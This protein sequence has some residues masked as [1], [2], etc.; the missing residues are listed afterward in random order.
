MGASDGVT[1]DRVWQGEPERPKGG[2]FGFVPAAV[3]VISDQGEAPTG[4]LN[5]N[6]VAPAGVKADVYQ[7]QSLPGFQ[8]PVGETG[9]FDAF[10]HATD[11]KHFIFPTVLPE[12]IL[13]GACGRMGAPV[14]QGQVLLL[15]M[16][17]LHRLETGPRRPAGFGRRP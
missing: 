9:G 6:L 16:P 15:E 4:K 1:C 13:P 2:G 7:R 8:N 12:Q 5:P 3:F 17:S 11:H 10:P 14:H